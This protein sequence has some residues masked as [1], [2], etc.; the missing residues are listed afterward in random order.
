M[1]EK[2][3]ENMN[4]LL[5][6]FSTV[7]KAN[8]YITFA[9]SSL[10][11]HWYY[12]E[13]KSGDEY[14]ILETVPDIQYAYDKMIGECKYYWLNKNSLVDSELSTEENINALSNENKE[15]LNTFLQDYINKSKQFLS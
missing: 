14:D 2:T 10:E 5:S 15:R 13:A 6:I 7:I 1:S 9:Y 11:D 8:D 3:N 12:L 4:Q